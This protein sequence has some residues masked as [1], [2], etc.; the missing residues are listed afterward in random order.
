MSDNDGWRCFFCGE[1]FTTAVDARNHFGADQ[2]AE[3]ACRIKADGEFALL[4]ALRNAEDR[5]ARYVAED[6]DILRAMYAMQADHATKVRRAE[7]QGYARGLADAHHL[8][9]AAE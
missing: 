1:V 9:S 4:K 3:T 6:S 5:L 2:M 7:E 8:R